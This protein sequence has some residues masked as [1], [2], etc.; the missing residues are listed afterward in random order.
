LF[1]CDLDENFALD[2]DKN[3]NIISGMGYEYSYNWDGKLRTATS[4][5]SDISFKYDPNNV[6]YEKP[7]WET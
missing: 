7:R 1:C 3:G 4:T 6:Y 2:Y 5:E